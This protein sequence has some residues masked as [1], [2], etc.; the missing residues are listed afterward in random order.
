LDV[1]IETQQ[2]ADNVACIVSFNGFSSPLHV[3]GNAHQFLL[4]TLHTV[5]G[6]K[7]TIIKP[8]MDAIANKEYARALRG[9]CTLKSQQAVLVVKAL[10]AFAN[11][12]PFNTNEPA[13]AKM[14]TAAHHAAI[15]NRVD[16]YDLILSSTKYRDVVNIDGKFASEC[17]PASKLKVKNGN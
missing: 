7:I 9:A 12:V 16:L 13:G 2:Q 6:E 8:I 17:F 11:K 10:L 1:V 15:N 14:L 4:K 3:A 5:F